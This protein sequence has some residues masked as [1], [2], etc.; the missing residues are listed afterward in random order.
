VARA[1]RSV[2]LLDVVVKIVG[3]SHGEELRVWQTIEHPGV[4]RLIAAAI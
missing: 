3:V 4:R 1:S 2:G